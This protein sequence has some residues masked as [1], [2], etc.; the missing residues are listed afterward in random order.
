MSY[1]QTAVSQ[2]LDM[3]VTEITISS[4]NH[5]TLPFI[6]RASLSGF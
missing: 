6:A 3:T 5:A 2:E 4:L 1:V